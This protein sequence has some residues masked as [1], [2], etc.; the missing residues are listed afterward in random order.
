MHAPFFIF[1]FT[2]TLNFMHLLFLLLISTIL[3]ACSGRPD[4]VLS[5]TEMEEVLYDYHMAQGAMDVSSYE[6]REQIAESYR[7]AV[8]EKHGITEA[9]FDS[10]LVYYN[11]HSTQ[12]NDIY[13]RL[14]DRFTEDSEQMKLRSGSDEM[15][16]A[17]GDGGDTTNIW[18]GAKVYVLRPSRMLNV[19]RFEMKADTSFHVADRFVFMVSMQ[20]VGE[21][22][23]VDSNAP[24]ADFGITIEYSD[25]TTIGTH[26]K[27]TYGG[28]QQFSLDS[29]QDKTIKSITGYLYYSGLQEQRNFC[30]MNNIGLF[31]I[32]T[33]KQDTAETAD[34]LVSDTT[35]TATADTLAMPSRHVR[36]TPE[37]IRTR[38]VTDPAHERQLIKNAPDVRT[39]NS[40]GTRRR[41]V[42][43]KR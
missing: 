26:R 5:E 27:V 34:S 29:K 35:A 43:R 9:E 19:E 12:L 22:S 40:F 33:Q 7:Q 10:S 42:Q 11:R 28:P 1:Q 3:V 16:S 4:G 14:S 25:S 18:S 20:F 8:F 41:P 36:L 17:L 37:E 21:S 24:Y 23:H 2:P 38:R 15:I 13:K 30:V 31:R 39:P 32:H 6:E